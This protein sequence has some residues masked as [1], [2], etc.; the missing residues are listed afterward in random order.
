[1]GQL[2]ADFVKELGPKAGREAFAN[3][4]AAGM[5]T[6]TAGMTPKRNLLA[7]HAYRWSARVIVM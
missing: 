3:R 4:F 5:A 2:E 6:T 7:T 1:M